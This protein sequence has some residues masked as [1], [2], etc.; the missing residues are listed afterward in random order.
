M[1]RSA[2]FRSENALFHSSGL[3]PPFSAAYFQIA[4]GERRAVRNMRAERVSEVP[5]YGE[6]FAKRHPPDAMRGVRPE[7]RPE[8]GGFLASNR[9]G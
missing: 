9:R 6:R 3:T 8:F 2:I 5:H 1:Y 4:D 7:P